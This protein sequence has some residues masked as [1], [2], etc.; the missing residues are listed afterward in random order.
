PDAGVAGEP[1]LRADDENVERAVFGRGEHWEQSGPVCV[2]TL[3]PAVVVELDQLP[4]AM[5]A[6]LL[7]STT[8]LVEVPAVLLLLGRTHADITRSAQRWQRCHLLGHRGSLR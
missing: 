2:V 4:A 8:I 3:A 5:A 1:V 6:D 7:D